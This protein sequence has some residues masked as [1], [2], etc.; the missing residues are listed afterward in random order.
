MDLNLLSKE[1]RNNL[2]N[3]NKSFIKNVIIEM[4]KDKSKE[5]SEEDLSIGIFA[6]NNAC[7]A[8]IDTM[9]N[10]YNYS[11]AIIRNH[12]LEYLWESSNTPQFQL[13]FSDNNIETYIKLNDTEKIAES[14]IYAKEIE[15]FNETLRSY[16][17]TYLNLLKNCSYNKNIKNDILNIAFLCSKE[18]FILNLIKENKHIPIDKISILTKYK[19]Q[20]IEKWKDYIL[21][22]I[23]IFSN[24]DLLYLRTYLNINVGDNK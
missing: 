6:F 7:N 16:N 2:I 11:R 4:K 22:L 18:L 15:L 21:G 13:Y 17:L 23:I 1:N 19:S 3:S 24:K 8:Y 12:F 20:F 14:K 9:G 5:I 10:F